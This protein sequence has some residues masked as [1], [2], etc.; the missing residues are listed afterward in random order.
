MAWAIWSSSAAKA[1]RRRST[2]SGA[3]AV[4]IALVCT[5]RRA[6]PVLGSWLAHHRNLGIRDFYLFA[7]EADELPL[8][9]SFEQDGVR[10]F[11]RGEALDA[12]WQTTPLW[13][14]FR[15]YLDE[16][17]ARQCLNVDLTMALARE[18]GVDWLLHLDIDE[19]LCIAGRWP[20]LATFFD[21]HRHC[22][23]V[24]FTNHE[25]V[26]EAWHIDDYFAEVTLFKR[27]PRMLDEARL[28]AT[29]QVFGDR[30][31]LAYT[32]GKSA[33]RLAGSCTRSYGAHEFVPCERR[34]RTSEICVLH[35]PQCGFNWY[36]SKFTTLG[37]FKDQLLGLIDIVS[38]HPFL[39]ESRSAAVAG[40]IHEQTRLYATQIMR[41]G[42]LPGSCEALL[43]QNIL[44]RLPTPMTQPAPKPLPPP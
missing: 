14:F 42:G 41:Q 16:V 18:A 28:Q 15:D 21:T 31:F 36:H 20:S 37:A 24:H 3:K 43:R 5:L 34:I 32:N 22:D 35:Y 7:D 2:P 23:M 27:N 30:Y 26:P 39:A 10:L 25:A 11:S 19:L 40:S 6:Q 17:Y 13:T 9:Q 12:Q 29:R 4:R 1:S 44:F 8:Y 33:A 38:T